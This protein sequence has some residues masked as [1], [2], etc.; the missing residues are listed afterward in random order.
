MSSELKRVLRRYLNVWMSIYPQPKMQWRVLFCICRKHLTCEKSDGLSSMNEEASKP[1]LSISV[2]TCLSRSFNRI[3]LF[4]C[5]Q[6]FFWNQCPGSSWNFA[7][8]R[9]IEWHKLTYKSIYVGECF[10]VWSQYLLVSEL[11]Q[12]IHTAPV[13]MTFSYIH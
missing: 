4:L 1:P 12:G 11:K 3:W 7:S 13:F 8:R 5:S 2:T 10:D 6:N 9:A